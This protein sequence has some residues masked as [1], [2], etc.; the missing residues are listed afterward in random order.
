MILHPGII[1]LLVTTVLVLGMALYGTYT[2]AIVLARWDLDRS[3]EEQLT[4]ERK[5]YLRATLMG[6]AL[7]LEVL[8]ALVFLYT[9]DDIHDIFVGAMCATGTLNA[10]PVGW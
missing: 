10:N 4:L 9:L 5:T 6:H 8:S 2:G 1:A 3:F 7:A